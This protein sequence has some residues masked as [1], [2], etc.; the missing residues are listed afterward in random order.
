MNK[1]EFVEAVAKKAKVS[2]AAAAAVVAAMQA[3]VTERVKKGDTVQLTGFVT[4]TV[5]KR[6]ARNGRN[7]ATGKT[8]KIAARKVVKVKA[9]KAL[10]DAV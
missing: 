3:V 8:I 1:T 7:P 10:K 6:A 4:F 9:G 5:A 2:K